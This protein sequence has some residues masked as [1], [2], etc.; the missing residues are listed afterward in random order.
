MYE[1][2]VFDY[3]SA[4]HFLKLY[5]GTWEKPHLHDWKV[6]VV[7]RSEKLDSMGVVVD[8]EAL[9]PCL[10]KVLAEF[11]EGSFNDHPDFRNEKLNPSAE[12]I[13]KLIY[14]RLL[15]NFKSPNAEIIKVTVW[16]TPEASAT[17]YA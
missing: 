16:E 10:K 15:K 13:A 8:F 3:F 6:S 7:M 4:E 9:K 14:E 2:E 11:H 1:I 5:D 17:Y 12:N